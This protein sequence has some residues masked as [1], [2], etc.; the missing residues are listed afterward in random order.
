MEVSKMDNK[1]LLLV[2]VVTAGVLEAVEDIGSTFKKFLEVKIDSPRSRRAIR[3]LANQLRNEVEQEENH[4]SLVERA[5]LVPN[6]L[7]VNPMLRLSSGQLAFSQNSLLGFAGDGLNTEVRMPEFTFVTQVY[8]GFSQ[9]VADPFAGYLPA[10]SRHL[11]VQ[12]IPQIDNPV[13]PPY[14]GVPHRLPDGSIFYL[15]APQ[16][17]VMFPFL[18]QAAVC[19]ALA[20][21][22]EEVALAR[23]AGTEQ[24]NF[25]LSGNADDSDD[26]TVSDRVIAPDYS[27]SVKPTKVVVAGIKRLK[28]RTLL[29]PKR[30]EYETEQE[31]LDVFSAWNSRR[32]TNK[33]SVNRTRE[34]RAVLI[35]ELARS[36]VFLSSE[37]KRNLPMDELKK[38]VSDKGL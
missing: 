13:P 6:S 36:G 37:D 24:E 12:H 35:R 27:A 25:Q 31:F 8:R 20:P 34:K 18:S 23:S 11:I 32:N 2:M 29:K 4:S 26:A 1:K 38:M 33:V 16:A 14:Y 21:R 9:H 7:D 19:A 10:D 30:S 5:K 28:S 17:S 15:P 3:S 22:I